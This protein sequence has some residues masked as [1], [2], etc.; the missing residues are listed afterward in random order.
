V[1]AELRAGKTELRLRTIAPWAATWT[2]ETKPADKVSATKLAIKISECDLTADLAGGRFRG[3]IVGEV[4]ATALTIEKESFKDPHIAFELDVDST[5]PNDSQVQLK[6]TA[7]AAMWVGVGKLPEK[8]FT[9][10]AGAGSSFDQLRG[11]FL[12]TFTRSLLFKPAP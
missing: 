12:R 3:R 5:R 4:S 9:I 2:A 8:T 7:K 10:C 11:E 6:L 1:T